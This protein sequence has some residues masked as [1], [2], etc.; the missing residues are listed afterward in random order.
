[1]PLA[2]GKT[3]KTIRA[4]ISE[5]IRLGRSREEAVRIAYGTAHTDARRAKLPP[6][7]LKR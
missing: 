4:N 3:S 1:M 2:H 5:N 7:W 6:K